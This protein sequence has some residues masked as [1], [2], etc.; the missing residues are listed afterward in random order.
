MSISKQST[1]I[2]A[3]LKWLYLLSALWSWRLSGPRTRFIKHNFKISNMWGGM[4]CWKLVLD[5]ECNWRKKIKASFRV[6]PMH[7]FHWLNK[8]YPWAYDRQSAERS[9]K[10]AAG[11]TFGKTTSNCENCIFKRKTL[12]FRQQ[13]PLHWHSSLNALEDVQS[14][15]RGWQPLKSVSQI[16]KTR[17]RWRLSALR[18]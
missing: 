15:I 11:L 12:I 10:K 13:L 8:S 7:L 6:R 1:I 3:E 16:V 2:H 9:K 17:R 14:H 18:Q 4:L 5:M